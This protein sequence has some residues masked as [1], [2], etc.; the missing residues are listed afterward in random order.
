LTSGGGDPTA[1][2][3]FAKMIQIFGVNLRTIAVDLVGSAALF[4]FFAAKERGAHSDARFLFHNLAANLAGGYSAQEVLDL[5]S[6]LARMQESM[7][8]LL[9]KLTGKTPEEIMAL[10]DKNQVIGVEDMVRLGLL[11]GIIEITP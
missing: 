10:C 11:H 7:F 1:G 8:G 9:A 4:I 2:M 3:H 6:H 5:A